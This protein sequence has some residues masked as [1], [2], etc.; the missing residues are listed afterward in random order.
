MHAHIVFC[1]LAPA[2][3]QYHS[4]LPLIADKVQSMSQ[5]LPRLRKKIVCVVHSSCMDI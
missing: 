5:A 4:H 3:V 2:A 1:G